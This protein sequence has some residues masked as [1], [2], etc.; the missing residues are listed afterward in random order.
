MTTLDPTRTR[1]RSLDSSAQRIEK[2]ITELGSEHE[3]QPD[4]QRRVLDVIE[5]RRC[6]ARRL[7]IAAI[8]VWAALATAW[9]YVQR[10]RVNEATGMIRRLELRICRD[11]CASAAPSP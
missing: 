4:W 6:T 8:I 11:E 9:A 10:S 3:P 7:G 2:T 1:G 5:P